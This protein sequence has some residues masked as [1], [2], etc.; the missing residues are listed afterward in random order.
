MSGLSQKARIAL[1]EK[2]GL[3]SLVSDE[4]ITKVN[5]LSEDDKETLRKFLISPPRTINGILISGNDLPDTCKDVLEQILFHEGLIR[6][7]LL[8]AIAN[9]PDAFQKLAALLELN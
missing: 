6:L 1:E 7:S 8:S 2:G 4:A 3:T 5:S 9:L